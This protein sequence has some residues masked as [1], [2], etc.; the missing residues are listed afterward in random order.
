MTC[1]MEYHLGMEL[2]RRYIRRQKSNSNLN[3]DIALYMQE[4]LFAE[5]L[6]RRKGQKRTL[7]YT[8]GSERVPKIELAWRGAPSPWL[9]FTSHWRGCGYSLPMGEKYTDLPGQ[10]WTVIGSGTLEV[11]VLE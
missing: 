3:S 6:L 8:Q 2:Q 4:L 5:T 7:K 9:G 1:H 11:G 10:S